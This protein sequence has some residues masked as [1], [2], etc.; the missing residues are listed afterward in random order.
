V[1]AYSIYLLETEVF[2]KKAGHLRLTCKLAGDFDLWSRFYFFRPFGVTLTFG[3][4]VIKKP[5]KLSTARTIFLL[6]QK[7]S[8]YYAGFFWLL[9]ILKAHLTN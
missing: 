5:E 1:A 8:C 4:F 3:G 7:E 9:T 6:N 2:G